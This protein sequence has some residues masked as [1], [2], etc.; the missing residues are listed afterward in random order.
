MNTRLRYEFFTI[1]YQT[2]STL[3]FYDKNVRNFTCQGRISDSSRVRKF[4]ANKATAAFP[5]SRDRNFEKKRNN[6]D[7]PQDLIQKPKP[8]FRT[9]ENLFL[10][11]EDRI[12]NAILTSVL[13]YRRFLRYCLSQRS[14][15]L[16]LPRSSVAFEVF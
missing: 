14:S 12:F 15:I 9:I 3:F 6:N 1:S 2:K 10:C 5:L 7:S 13:S 4:F 8:L 16:K 11:H